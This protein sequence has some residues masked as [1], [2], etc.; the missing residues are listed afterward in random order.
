MQEPNTE[1]LLSNMIR[2]FWQDAGKPAIITFHDTKFEFIAG[3]LDVMIPHVNMISQIQIRREKSVTHK[4]SP[5][6]VFDY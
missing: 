1:N 5:V 6:A 3:T 4:R 2:N